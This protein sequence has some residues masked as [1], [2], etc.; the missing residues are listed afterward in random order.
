MAPPGAATNDC[1]DGD[2]TDDF[3]QHPFPFVIASRVLG[4]FL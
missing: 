2:G 3:V 4:P 1:Q